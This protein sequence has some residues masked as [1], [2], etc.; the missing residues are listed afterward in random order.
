[1][2]FKQKIVSKEHK[3]IRPPPEC[4][5]FVV[6][7]GK[8]GRFVKDLETDLRIMLAPYTFDKLRVNKKNKIRDFVEAAGDLQATMMIHLSSQKEK[9]V[10]SFNRFPHG[11]TLHFNIKK[12]ATMADVRNGN[13]ESAT[14]NKTHPG[15][16]FPILEGF[17]E[18]NEDQTVVSM[19]QGLFPSFDPNTADLGLMKRAVLISKGADGEISIRHYLVEKTD[20]KESAINEAVDKAMNV[21]LSKYNSMAEYLEELEKTQPKRDKKIST[22]KLKELGP[23]VEIVLDY[24]EMNLY[25]GMKM[26]EQ[27]KKSQI[28]RAQEAKAAKEEKEKMKKAKVL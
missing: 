3:I 14:I 2:T 17:G 4:M 18:S 1:M 6:H 24:V 21:D 25:G 10:F 28:K 12:F 5:T 22:I 13:K 15:E 19:F 16:A 11:P 9:L 20:P 8:V 27:I 26:Q 7:T 23:R